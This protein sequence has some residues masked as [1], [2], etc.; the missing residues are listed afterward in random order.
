MKIVQG[1]M[2][3]GITKLEFG[4]RSK[5]GKAK[6]TVKGKG[7]GLTLPGMPLAQDTR[8]TVQLVTSDGV[9]WG[10]SYEPP[11]ARND[12]ERFKDSH[13]AAN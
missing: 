8:V 11:A 13:K 10:A 9:C 1:T 4:T 5:R 7:E 2:Y 6:G 12:G 3:K